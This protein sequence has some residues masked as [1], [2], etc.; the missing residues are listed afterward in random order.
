ML[1][2]PLFSIGDEQKTLGSLLTTAVVVSTVY[3]EGRLCKL[4]SLSQKRK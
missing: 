2:W 3:P 1:S 4:T